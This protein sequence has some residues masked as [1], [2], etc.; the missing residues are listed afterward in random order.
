MN[1]RKLDGPQAKES[2]KRR[3]KA[4]SNNGRD[5]PPPTGTA[6]LLQPQSETAG[7]DGASAEIG[8]GEARRYT[9][10]GKLLRPG[11]I[12]DYVSGEP[13]KAGP[14]EVEATQ[15]I[16]RRLVEEYGWPREHIR[17]RPQF[18]VKEYPSDEEKWPVDAAIFTVPWRTAGYSDLYAVVEC[19]RKERKDGVHQLQIYLQNAPSA[20]LGIWY[21]GQEQPVV[22][23]KRIKPDGSLEFIPLVTIPR[24]G[25]DPG[26]LTR[27]KRDDLSPPVDLV[28]TFKEI[29]NYLAGM[30]T[31]ISRDEPL[32][33]QMK[34]IGLLKVYDELHTQR[35]ATVTVGVGTDETN[36]Q[37]KE[38]LTRFFEQVKHEY[39]T[40]FDEGDAILL[41][42]DSLAYVVGQL[43]QLAITEAP[44]H[45]LISAF[46]VFIGPA[47]RGTEG[48]F[49]TPTNAVEAIITILDP[50]PDE[51]FLDDACG[52][53]TFLVEALKHVWRKLEEQAEREGWPHERLGAE[54]AKYIKRYLRGID[55]DGFLA[56]MAAAWI[57]FY[58]ATTGD[59]TGGTVYVANSL[60]SPSD[61]PP[62][63]QKDIKLGKWHVM[64]VNPPYGSK[65]KVRGENILKQFD[66]AHRWGK[67]ED[68]EGQLVFEKGKLL[69]EQAPQLLF[70]ERN[71]QFLAEGGRMGIVLLESIFGMPKYRYVI[72]WLLKHAEVYAIISMPEDLF[73]P[74]THAKTCLVFL[75]KTSNPRAEYPIFMAVAKR[76]GHDSMARPIPF[77]DLPTIAE[78]YNQFRPFIEAHQPDPSTLD[79]IKQDHLGFILMRSQLRDL[80]LIPKY[81][82]PEIRQRLEALRATHEL[83]TF[84]ELN[85]RPALDEHGQVRFRTSRDGTPVADADGNPV[86]L[87]VVEWATGHEPGKLEYGLGPVPF[88]R[89]SDIANWELK[90]DPKQSLSEEL[91]QQYKDVQDVRAEDILMVR[92]G[93]YLVGTTCMLTEFDTRI[94]FCGGMYKIRVND[95]R[96]LDPYLLLGVL[97]SPLVKK[98]IR[99]KQFTRDV[100]DTLGH[101][102][103]ELVLPIPK[104]PAERAR[105][106]AEAREIVLERARLRERARQLALSVTPS[107]PIMEEDREEVEIL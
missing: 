75:R 39:E 32:A 22:L 94:V 54:K 93:T 81:Y 107:V 9:R 28:K 15:V 48:Q 74:H 53:G 30:A 4:Q 69:E 42:P 35:E 60:L 73:Q 71:L 17:T 68:E 29:R 83:V 40:L 106:A 78:R 67:D 36:V 21:N 64:G 25:Q 11:Y 1:G 2:M 31:G 45:A 6:D 50:R 59:D 103:R 26:A 72:D 34:I 63:M 33:R 105:I 14:E 5:V 23:W 55:K 62:E 46:E 89:T 92:D 76:C 98:Q 88:I 91:Y 84:D 58:A 10:T 99:A 44:R 65:I 61:W 56:R 24:W 47:T 12:E 57:T 43:N 70:L 95:K 82:D 86:P 16:T 96:A 100:I 79:G 49:H 52:G 7:G 87:P 51:Y 18:K 97:N 85:K 80:I 90:Y 3:R 77:D 66:L 38:R 13:V 27:P 19:K 101:R 8:E 37:L 20:K 104:D 102:I 41:D